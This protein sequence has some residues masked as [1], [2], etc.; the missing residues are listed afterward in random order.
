MGSSSFHTMQLLRERLPEVRLHKV[1]AP[2]PLHS[3]PHTIGPSTRSLS[4]A[5]VGPPS[6]PSLPLPRRCSRLGSPAPE[7]LLMRGRF[8]AGVAASRIA[9]EHWKRPKMAPSGHPCC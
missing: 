3:F 6:F 7:F 9:S 8:T 2:V 1:P 4:L 5:G